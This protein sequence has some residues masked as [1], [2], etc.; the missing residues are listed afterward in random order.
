MYYCHISIYFFFKKICSIMK[1]EVYCSFIGFCGKNKEIFEL[2]FWDVD[3]F[4]NFMKMDEK[5]G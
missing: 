4:Y 2:C 5:R 3:I 1:I